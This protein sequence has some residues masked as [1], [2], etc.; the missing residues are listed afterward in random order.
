VPCFISC[1]AFLT[2]RPLALLYL[3]AMRDLHSDVISKSV[4]MRP[5]L[6]LSFSTRRNDPAAK[7]LT[8]RLSRDAAT[9]NSQPIINR[10]LSKWCRRKP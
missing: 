8:D 7:V 5:R 2:L 1:I 9:H 10:A 3:R 4:T 6:F